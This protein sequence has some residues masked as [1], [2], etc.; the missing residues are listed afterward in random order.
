MIE[1]DTGRFAPYVDLYLEMVDKQLT[2]SLGCRQVQVADVNLRAPRRR[3]KH[4][5]LF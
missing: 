3:R 1:E 2:F 4:E 5:R